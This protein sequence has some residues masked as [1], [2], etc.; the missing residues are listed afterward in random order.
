MSIKPYTKKQNQK[1]T[2]NKSKTLK[3][4]KTS[5][6]LKTS[7]TKSKFIN[8]LSYNISWESMTGSV[9]DWTL[10]SNN[11]NKN[12]HKH[13]SVCVSNIANVINNNNNNDDN[14][15]NDNSLD[16]ITLQEATNYDKLIEQS[17]VLKKM[18]YE[19]HMSRL[20]TIVTF[21]K[22]NYKL[23]YTIKGEFEKGRPWIATLF[24]NGICVIN[25][26]MGHST[27]DIKYYKLE[28]LL[29]SIKDYIMK[30]GDSKIV[31][32]Y[33][34]SGDFNYNIKEFG[35]KENNNKIKNK[36]KTNN[37]YNNSKINNK[38][39]LFING[40]K[41]YY[42]SKHILTCCIKRS[43]HYDHVIDT[44]NAPVNIQIPK[45]N[46]MASDHKPIIVTLVK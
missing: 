12:H 7:K 1:Y 30:K 40:T 15:N 29:F 42:H 18:K 11:T 8:I 33:I 27:K 3:T 13:Y 26:H 36:S 31:K 22:G 4:S 24:T 20:D 2:Y 10:C 35:K 39:S 6:T 38:Y 41:F 32:R 28:V 19:T 14:N 44:L 37:N 9:S 45:V 16:F 17:P 46:Y 25:V 34:I 5:K 23:L 21:W 43:T